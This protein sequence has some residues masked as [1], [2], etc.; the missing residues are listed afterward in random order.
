MFLAWFQLSHPF[1][2]AKFPALKTF[3]Y[4]THD[5]EKTVTAT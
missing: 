3:G 2:R 4:N 1:Q 5:S